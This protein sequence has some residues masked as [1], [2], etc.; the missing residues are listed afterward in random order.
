[1]PIT[2]GIWWPARHRLTALR[3]IVLALLLTL[4]YFFHLVSLGLTIGGLFVLS[5]ASPVRNEGAHAWHRRLSRTAQTCVTFFPVVLLGLYYLSIATQRA[6]MRPQWENLGDVGSPTAWLA[7]LKWADPISLAIRDGIPGTDR[8]SL[9][10]IV[11]APVV[12]LAVAI[13]FWCF[14]MVSARFSVLTNHNKACW[15]LLA[16]VLL[17]GGIAGPDSL[18]EAHGNY[19]PQRVV[20]LGLVALVPAF[21][22]DPARWW[23][24]GCAAAL[25]AA[26]ALQ[27]AVVWDYA[28]YCD[29]TAGQMIRARNAIGTGQRI[30]ALLISTH[31]RFRS[32]PLLHAVDWL[33]VD[34]G[35]IVW[36]NYETLHYYF[37]VQFRTGIDR[38]LPD[39]LER[40]SLQEDPAH[41]AAREVAWAKILEQHAGSIDVLIVW[42]TDRALDAITAR[43]FDRVDR[44]GDIQI[45]RRPTSKPD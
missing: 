40:V 43:W 37:P 41:S 17:C 13:G 19:L 9:A 21:D 14:G 31:S 25:V 34:S 23:G 1:F 18:G 16:F 36:N 33:G 15:L 28:V 24:R 44:Q 35:N 2:L 3:L 29:R 8:S 11:F 4:G 6:P 27:S 42:K 5:V 32:N 10:F 38:P 20:L 45:Y 22:I 12:W 30:A 7:R 39:D 26:V